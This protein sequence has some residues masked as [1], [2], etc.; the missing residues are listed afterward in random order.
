MFELQECKEIEYEY[1]DSE[2]NVC[3]NT[4]FAKKS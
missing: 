1:H 2:V 3:Y 4:Y